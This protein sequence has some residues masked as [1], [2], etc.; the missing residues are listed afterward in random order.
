MAISSILA[1]NTRRIKPQ[2]VADQLASSVGRQKR[3]KNHFVDIL[4][5][6]LLSWS[7]YSMEY[8]VGELVAWLGV[9]EGLV[10]RTEQKWGLG[11]ALKRE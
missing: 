6:Q 8:S 9:V 1:S 11:L 4:V 2:G 7:L 10:L 5:E 3:W